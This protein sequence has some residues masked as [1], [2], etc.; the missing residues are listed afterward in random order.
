MSDASVTAAF[1]ALGGTGFTVTGADVPDDLALVTAGAEI[2]LSETARINA[3]FDGEFAP[4]YESYAGS[5][6]LRF[7][8]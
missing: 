1:P 5:V 6:A 3:S 2:S 8:W 4:D 7:I